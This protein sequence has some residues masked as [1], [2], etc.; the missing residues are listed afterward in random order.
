MIHF[1]WFECWEKWNRYIT[2]HSDRLPQRWLLLA[3]E[4]LRSAH[5]PPQG[6]ASSNYDEISRAHNSPEL[7]P[8]DENWDWKM[9]AALDWK[10][11]GYDNNNP[12]QMYG[13]NCQPPLAPSWVTAWSGRLNPLTAAKPC[14]SASSWRCLYSWALS[15]YRMPGGIYVLSPAPSCNFLLFRAFVIN[16][17]EKVSGIISHVNC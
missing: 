8:V 7:E 11:S 13:L 6:E 9:I 15:A 1:I 4:W 3:P 10:D 5:T 2:S 17:H 16:S 14:Y 12:A